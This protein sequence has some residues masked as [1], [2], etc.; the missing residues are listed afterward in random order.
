MSA[1][2]TALKAAGGLVRQ[3]GSL[4]GKGARMAGTRIAKNTGPW[5]AEGLA[6]QFAPD[7][8]F[9]GISGAMTPGDLSDKL[10]A[11]STQAIGGGVGGLTTRGL[12]GAKGNAGILLSEMVGG[13]GGDMAGAQVGD[14]ILRAKGGGTTPWEK[15]SI[16]QEELLRKQIYEQ[17]MREQGLA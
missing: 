11:G 5:T 13:I 12:L 6:M 7:V 16:E 9:G 17:I 15:L 2:G 4:V 10:I 1:L 14:A 3:G 8:L